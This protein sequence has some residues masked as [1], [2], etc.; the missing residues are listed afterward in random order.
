[1]KP[2]TPP[3]RPLRGSAASLAARKNVDRL[4]HHHTI[5][6]VKKLACFTVAL[7]L[8][9]LLLALAIFIAVRA[10][11]ADEDAVSSARHFSFAMVALTAANILFALISVYISNRQASEAREYA[12]GIRA[13][14][15]PS[16]G[17][18]EG[19]LWLGGCA[20][21]QILG[22]ELRATVFN[23]S[24]LPDVI[25]IEGRC[26]ES[27]VTFADADS[28]ELIPVS[29]ETHIYL[30]P[31]PGRTRGRE[32]ASNTF[33]LA[34]RAAKEAIIDFRFEAADLCLD[35][36]KGRQLKHLVVAFKA[37]SMTTRAAWI[38]KSEPCELDSHRS[39]P[40]R[41]HL[42]M[43]VETAQPKTTS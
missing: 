11:V 6:G 35:D 8:A 14:E 22:A 2:L 17:I 27:S 16:L 24:T 33:P 21:T 1:M 43:A 37:I 13:R 30:D 3:L 29:V 34:G 40:I 23:G 26:P 18:T 32:A 7:V 5:A 41:F 28:G 38:W 25:R 12:D 15:V 10:Y 39:T 4:S 42:P 19:R 9:G 31:P 36:M 20:K